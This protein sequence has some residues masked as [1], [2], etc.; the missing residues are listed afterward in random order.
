MNYFQVVGWSVHGES[1]ILG[2]LYVD[3]T[4]NTFF[5]DVEV[6]YFYKVQSHMNICLDTFLR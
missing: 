2:P 3:S 6:G 5:L 4:G 1:G